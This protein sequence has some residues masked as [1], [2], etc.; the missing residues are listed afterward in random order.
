MNTTE[1]VW[2]DLEAGPLKQALLKLELYAIDRGFGFAQRWVQSEFTGYPEPLE[3]DMPLPWWRDCTVVWIGHDD[4]RIGTE[5]D[6]DRDQAWVPYGIRD[7]EDQKMPGLPPNE[8]RVRGLPPN[9]FRIP[10]P[11]G[12]EDEIAFGMVSI[13]PLYQHI[14]E[15]GL[16]ILADMLRL[17]R[18]RDK[19]AN[20]IVS[21]ETVE[22]VLTGFHA[23]TLHLQHRKR[24]GKRDKSFEIEDEYDVQDLLYALLR[25]LVPDLEPEDPVQKVAGKGSFLDFRS[26]ELRLIIE[27]KY[28]NS[29]E[30]ARALV[31]ECSARINRYGRKV[32]LDTLVF[33]IYDPESHLLRSHPNFERD[34][35]GGYK[36][37]GSEGFRVEVVINP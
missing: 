11:A 36:V 15:G 35:E 34:M 37:G 25:P 1:E 26:D 19:G 14:R 4:K 23:A 9:E 6:P 20:N 7:I 2:K 32:D 10:P 30:R 22:T 17:E 33:F 16:R 31:D 21:I 8:F 28:C 13:H 5:Y 3:E 18:E 29:A 27:A 12:K 24:K